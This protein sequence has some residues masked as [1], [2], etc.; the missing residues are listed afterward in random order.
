VPHLDVITEYRISLSSQEFR[1]LLKALACE[2]TEQKDID[3]AKALC[4]RLAD[5]RLKFFD[6]AH[7]AVM[8]SDRQRKG[9]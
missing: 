3:E 1:L 8:R 2:L 5:L 6:N 7:A 4:G 9:E